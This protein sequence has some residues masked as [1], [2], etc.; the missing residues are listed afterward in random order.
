MGEAPEILGMTPAMQDVFRAI[1]RLSQS[2]R[3]VLITGESGTGKELVARALHRHSARAVAPFVA[4]TTAATEDLL[5]SELF[6]HERGSFTARSSSGAALEQ[7]EGGTLFLDEIGDSRRSCRRGPARA[8][9]GLLPRRRHRRSVNVRP[10]IAA[11]HQNLDS[12]CAT[13]PSARLFHRLNVIRCAAELARTRG[14]HTFIVKTFSCRH[15]QQS[16]SSRR[17]R[18]E[19]LQHLSRL[20]LPER[21][22]WKPVSLADGDGAGAGDRVGDLPAEF[23]DQSTRR[24]RGLALGARAGSRAPVARGQTGI[25]R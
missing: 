6:G 17:A 10:V 13:A 11:T 14:K 20:E 7:A 24:R 8:L 18:R 1:W 4:I 12:A 15:A 25:P 2:R 23:R 5:E 3:D 22:S 21:A 19:A 9:H 16:A